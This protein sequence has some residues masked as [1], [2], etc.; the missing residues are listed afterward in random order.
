MLWGGRV[1]VKG[2]LWGRGREFIGYNEGSRK[3]GLGYQGF[4][5]PLRII[6]STQ[7][8]KFIISDKNPPLHLTKINKP[9]LI[10]QY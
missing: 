7:R 5:L 2:K 10:I 1:N 6:H 3:L 8:F 4:Y 9:H